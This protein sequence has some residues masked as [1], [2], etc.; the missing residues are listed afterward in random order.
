MDFVLYCMYRKLIGKTFD[1]IGKVH[2]FTIFFA[3]FLIMLLLFL[4]G[5]G[6]LGPI[7]PLGD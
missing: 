6:G 3:G 2:R 5:V 4:G 7:K 1:C